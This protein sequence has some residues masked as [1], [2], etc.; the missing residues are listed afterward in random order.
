[1][2]S[3]AAQCCRRWCLAGRLTGVIY[4]L[5]AR[6]SPVV[7]FLVG[8]RVERGLCRCMTYA[9][10]EPNPIMQSL[11]ATIICDAPCAPSLR[12]FEIFYA[13]LYAVR[14]RARVS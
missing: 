5:P 9:C 1:M 12:F 8:A 4:D 14:L 6:A 7:R 13:A 10:D 3:G 2:R 11:Y